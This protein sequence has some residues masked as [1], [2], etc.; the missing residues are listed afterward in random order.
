ML[1]YV[2]MYITM[3]SVFLWTYFGAETVSIYILTGGDAEFNDVKF[4]YLFNY[5]RM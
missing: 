1:I 5:V 4:T 2:C 3:Q